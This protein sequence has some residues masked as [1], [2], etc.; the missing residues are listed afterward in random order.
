MKN[1][2][3]M[4]GIIFDL[5]GVIV[6]TAK[7]HYLAWR[8]LADRL[9]FEFTP[10]HNERLKGVSRD[11]SLEI[12]LEVGGMAGE[13]SAAEK[14]AMATE[15][16]ERY[17]AY[18]RDLKQD[19]MLPGSRELLLELRKHGIKIGLG[20]ASKNAPE[21]LDKLGI[22]ELFD[23]IV[24]GNATQ[25]AKPDPAVF[26]LGAQ[27]MGID[28]ADCIVFEDAQAGIEAAL[29]AGMTPIAV[30][31]PTQLTGAEVYV[32]DLQ[33]VLMCDEKPHLS[34]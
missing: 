31:C 20:S 28:P 23:V 5:D 25:H 17:V 26:L 24:D 21:I 1:L 6:D 32:K 4:K 14:H 29:A 2:Y 3:E 18:I 13:F 22:T 12:L 10:E 7:Y 27:A 9:G 19:E 16:N 30:G 15:K 11:R 33:E 8:E 34:R